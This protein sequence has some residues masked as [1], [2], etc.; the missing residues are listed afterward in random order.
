VLNGDLEE[1]FRSW[2]P[3]FRPGEAAH[4]PLKDNPQDFSALLRGRPNN[5]WSPMEQDLAGSPPARR[6]EGRLAA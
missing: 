2:Y 4:A 3:S 5:I 1:T 6:T